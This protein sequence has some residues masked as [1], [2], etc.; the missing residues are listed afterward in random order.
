VIAR[1]MSLL[2][3]CVVVFVIVG[4]IVSTPVRAHHGTAVYDTAKLTTI[5]GTVTDYQFINPH[6]IILLDVKDDAGK[7][8]NWVL[9]AGSGT[10]MSRKG[11]T[12][13]LLKQGDQITAVGNRAKNGSPTMRL[14]KIALSNGK[15]YFV[16][17]GEDYAN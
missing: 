14:S 17:R 15:E 3:F 11:W 13:N 10:S 12:R 5:K 7:V 16:D 1:P 9:E 8:A 6:S 2:A 4:P